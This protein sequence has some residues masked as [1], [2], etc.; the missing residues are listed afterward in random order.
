MPTTPSHFE[1][2]LHGP[3]GTERDAS[4]LDEL[5]YDPPDGAS[6]PTDTCAGAWIA[7]AREID[8]RVPLLILAC[9]LG[10]I[11]ASLVTR[12]L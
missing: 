3:H 2:T 8:Y 11:V 12:A 10:S 4:V 1:A 6:V 9:L 5:R 7:A